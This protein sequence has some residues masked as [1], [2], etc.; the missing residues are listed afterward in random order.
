MRDLAIIWHKLIASAPASF[1][2]L[3]IILISFLS[4]KLVCKKVS[5]QLRNSINSAVWPQ[6]QFSPTTVTVGKRTVIKLI[7]H[8]GEFDGDA[9]FTKNIQYEKPVFSWLEDHCTDSYETVIEI[10]ANIGIYTCF[11]GKL[12]KGS[13]RKIIAFEPSPVAYSRLQENLNANALDS[14]LAFPAAVA[15]TAGWVTLYEPQ[16]HL[17]NGSLNQEFAGYFSDNIKESTVQAVDSTF[18]EKMVNEGEKILLKIDVE[19]YEPVLLASL[20]PFLNKYQPDILIEVLSETEGELSEW[21]KGKQ[22]MARVFTD[23]G[24]EESMFCAK[25][26]ARDWLF[27]S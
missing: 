14:S 5:T 27:E 16:S 26:G 8:I 4:R 2:K 24:L 7:P 21:L 13:D 12:F 3:Y 25:E 22:Y 11:F 18:L 15:E 10:G 1:A 23:N 9:L 19:G 20:E 6:L 17:T